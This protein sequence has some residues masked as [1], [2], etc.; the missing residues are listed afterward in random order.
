MIPLTRPVEFDKTHTKFRKEQHP[1]PASLENGHHIVL[2][3]YDGVC[4]IG[5][6]VPGQRPRMVSRTEEDYSVSCGLL[7]EATNLGLGR[8]G[9]RD[10]VVYTF[11]EVWRPNCPQPTI[12]GDFRQQRATVT[13]FVYVL[14][15]M[16]VEGQASPY[17]ARRADYMALAARSGLPLHAAQ[18]AGAGDPEK[19]ARLMGPGYDGVVV[20][21]R[22]AVPLMDAKASAGQAIKFKP[23]I[24]VDVRCTG[25]VQ[26]EGKH[27]GRLGALTFSYKGR[28]GSVGTGFSN[29]QRDDIWAVL[30][31]PHVSPEHKAAG[32]IIEIEAMGFTPDGSLREPRFRGFRYDKTKADDE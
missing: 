7:L 18:E 30:V 8:M 10:S 16:V 5:V 11:G 32:Q 26:G 9:L 20:W 12:S 15:D 19:L 22:R 25:G 31:A 21:D 13:D 24:T 23:N 1:T 6:F 17:A 28:P 14:F 27:A 2:K 29:Q 3:K 4:G